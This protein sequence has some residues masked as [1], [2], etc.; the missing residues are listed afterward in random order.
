MIYN[1]SIMLCLQGNSIG[2]VKILGVP[3]DIPVYFTSR[4]WNDRYR[5]IELTRF[6]AKGEGKRRW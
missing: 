6:V 4:Y 5:S 2:L 3:R 1:G